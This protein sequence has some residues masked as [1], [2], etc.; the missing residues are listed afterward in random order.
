M[1]P[2]NIISISGSP[3]LSCGACCAFYLAAFYWGE[4]DDCQ[5]GT[6]PVGMTEKLDHYRLI[7]KGTNEQEPRCIALQGLVGGQ[8]HCSIYDRRS[9]VCRDFPVAGENG[10][11]NERCD[12][13]RLAW[14]LSPLNPWSSNNPDNFE[15]VA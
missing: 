14:G 5:G 10:T 12:K 8:V 3:C 9:S 1:D 6:V 4:A 2:S 11:P 7:M 13:A 15:K